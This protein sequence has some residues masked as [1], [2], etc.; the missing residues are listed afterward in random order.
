MAV[1]KKK[2]SR[3]KTRKRLLSKPNLLDSTIYTQCGT[4]LNF[5]KKHTVC[6]RLLKKGAVCSEGNV[7]RKGINNINKLYELNF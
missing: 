2:I 1:P 6:L 7:Q 4:C 3:S 5:L